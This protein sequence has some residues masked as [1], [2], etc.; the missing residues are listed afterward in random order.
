MASLDWFFEEKDTAA[1][2]H[3]DVL[4]WQI[5]MK[6]RRYSSAVCR[7]HRER[8]GLSFLPAE[9]IVY[10][11]DSAGE[12][13]DSDKTRWD[14]RLNDWLIANQIAAE[15]P[16]NEAERFGFAWKSKL[17]PAASRY[18]D[19][20]FSAVLVDW[21]KSGPLAEQPAVKAI[22][23]KIS[24]DRPAPGSDADCREF[25]EKIIAESARA[26]IAKLRY[27]RDIA[28]RVLD[29]AVA[30]YLDERFS[31]TNRQLLGW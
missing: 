5:K 26:L 1:A 11:R 16:N 28:E 30:Y 18:G 29:K 31:V 24:Y 4:R 22:L 10:F 21:V 17:Q 15:S 14:S 8:D 12:S 27:P 7:L 6:D 20:F 9:I 13:F 2:D 19:G 25:I 23:E 3:P